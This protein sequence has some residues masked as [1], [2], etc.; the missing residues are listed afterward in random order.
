MRT[1]AIE[2]ARHNITINAIMPG[3]IMTEGLDDVGEDYL[4]TMEKAIPMGKLGTST[5]S[6]TR[7]CSSRR[8]KPNTSPARRS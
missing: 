2:L 7:C 8:T 5:I 1:A 6:H 3:N 4:R